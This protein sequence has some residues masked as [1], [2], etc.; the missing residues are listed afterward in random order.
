MYR[1]KENRKFESRIKLL[2]IK[3]YYI[4]FSIYKKLAINIIIVN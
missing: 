2:S 4:V 1:N 3:K